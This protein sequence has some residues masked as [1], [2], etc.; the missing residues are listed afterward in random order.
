VYF[1]V[2]HTWGAPPRGRQLEV[3]RT[4]RGPLGRSAV[5]VGRSFVASPGSEACSSGANPGGPTGRSR[6][7]R[8]ESCDRRPPPPPFPPPVRLRG[9]AATLVVC[10]CHAL[11]W[12][13]GSHPPISMNALWKGG[14]DQ[15][16]KRISDWCVRVGGGKGRGR[17][18]AC[19]SR[20]SASHGQATSGRG[21]SRAWLETHQRK[22]GWVA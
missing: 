7:Y 21:N 18:H 22:R 10:Q 5:S 12:H 11:C 9:C 4:A 8:A 14:E 19:R 16:A 15:Q 13:A 20:R 6:T 2:N 17:N 3:T 1:V